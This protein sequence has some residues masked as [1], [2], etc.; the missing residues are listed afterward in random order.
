MF[1]FLR[2]KSSSPHEDISASL[3]VNDQLSDF[4]D[5]ARIGRNSHGELEALSTQELA[6]SSASDNKKKEKLLLKVKGVI[7]KIIGAD[8]LKLY[9]D[10][11][12]KSQ[13]FE[14]FE[15]RKDEGTQS[16]FLS[17]R[18]TFNHSSSLI[19]EC[20]C[21][22]LKDLEIEYEH[23]YTYIPFRIKPGFPVTNLT[24]DANGIQNLLTRKG[25]SEFKKRYKLEML[26]LIPKEVKPASAITPPPVATTSSPVPE[27]IR[28][29]YTPSQAS[30]FPTP[31]CE[32]ERNTL[33]LL[34]QAKVLLEPVIHDFIAPGIS[35][36]EGFL[37]TRSGR[38]SRYINLRLILSSQRTNRLQ[39]ITLF[40][41]MLDNTGITYK[42]S[43]KEITPTP[44]TFKTVLHHILEI[45]EITPNQL[46]KLE[47]N[48]RSFLGKKPSTSSNTMFSLP[49]NSNF[50]DLS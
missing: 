41:Q 44:Y 43:I 48:V 30:D 34:E 31:T 29:A 17:L 46:T 18:T 12:M 19:H 50:Y 3:L 5:I 15:V 4:S 47:N 11:A 8:K 13:G 16:P 10:E 2:R 38:D 9:S 21:N 28:R 36:K 39:S 1:D 22:T 32:I 33:E 26:K 42:P 49:R 25:K 45:K 40:E 37:V 27:A 20:L 35:G 24:A 14:S 7:G 6:T 23:K